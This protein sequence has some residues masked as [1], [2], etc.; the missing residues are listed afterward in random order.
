MAP[1]C[2]CE[3]YKQRGLIPH[4]RVHGDPVL[5]AIGSPGFPRHVA[6]VAADVDLRA[7]ARGATAPRLFEAAAAELVDDLGTSF[8]MTTQQRNAARSLCA[9]HLRMAAVNTCA[10]L[11]SEAVIDGE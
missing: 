8:A 2:N 10:R 7:R 5:D 3:E 1:A 11:F 9:V 6:A 4:C